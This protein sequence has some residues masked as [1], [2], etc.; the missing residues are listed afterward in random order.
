[1]KLIQCIIQ[2]FKL[3]DVVDAKDYV[4][5]R[6]NLNKT[7][8]Q[9]NYT[10]WRA[11][12]GKSITN[13][14]TAAGADYDYDGGGLTLLTVPEPSALFLALSACLSGLCHRRRAKLD[15]FSPFFG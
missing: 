10:Q 2:P 14:P 9:S 5:W 1:M 12:F 11:N 15:H 13:R 6:T 4:L 7:L 3:D 8:T